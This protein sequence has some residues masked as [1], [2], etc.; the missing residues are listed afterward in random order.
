MVAPP[1]IDV[2]T[3]LRAM[4]D[5][6]AT[7]DGIPTVGNDRAV[8]YPKP[9]RLTV[10]PSV[11]LLWGGQNAPTTEISSAVGFHT[12]TAGITARLFVSTLYEPTREQ[13]RIDELITPISDL[14]R[15]TG[16]GVSTILPTLKGHV[17]NIEFI[18]V[19]NELQSEYGGEKCYVADVVFT[20][21]FKR[22]NRT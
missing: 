3:I 19:A 1:E 12:W 18:R 15:I 13:K 6:I 2:P 20:A 7:L 14:F 10:W 22:R 16:G 11:V 21:R 8:Y 4:R 9:A 17:D 5:R